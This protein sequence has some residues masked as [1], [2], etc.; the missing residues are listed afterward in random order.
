MGYAYASAS[1]TFSLRTCVVMPSHTPVSQPTRTWSS[2][3]LATRSDRPRST[4]TPSRGVLTSRT[5]HALELVTGTST[6][7]AMETL[8]ASSEEPLADA[9]CAN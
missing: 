9:G 6:T 3:N 2:L 8:R 5:T 4:A 7:V 1:T